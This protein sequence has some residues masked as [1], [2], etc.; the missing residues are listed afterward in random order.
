[1]IG[2]LTRFDRDQYAWRSG[3]SQ[4]PRARRLRWGGNLFHF[5]IL[6]LFFGHFVG[7]LTPPWAYE[8]LITPADKQLVAVTAGGIAGAI[9]FL[10][11]TILPHRRLYDERIRRTSTYADTFILVLLWVRLSLGLVTLPFSLGHRDGSVMLALSAWSQAIVTLQPGAADLIRGLDFPYHAHL[12]LG[13]TLFLVTPFTR[14]VHIFSAPVWY[15]F[16]SWRIVRVRGGATARPGPVQHPGVAPVLAD[17]PG[18]VA[19][20][21]RHH[22][23]DSAGAAWEAAARALVVRRLLREAVARAGIAGAEEMDEEDAIAALLARE[24]RIPTP[25]PAAAGLPP[26]RSALADRR[27]GRS[28]TFSSPP[29]RR[30]RRTAPWPTPGRG[31]RSRRSRRCLGVLRNSRGSTRTALPVRRLAMNLFAPHSRAVVTVSRSR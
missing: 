22:P 1:L 2:S 28:A 5:G 9:R 20:K 4:M 6:F 7:L 8:W 16:R 25:P 21:M 12:V 31:S 13:M 11:L 3:S 18:R 24:P 19:A 17:G 26:I 23:A 27:R 15:L 30:C 14:L 10:G 29:I